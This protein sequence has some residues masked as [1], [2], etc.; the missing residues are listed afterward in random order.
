MK[1]RAIAA[2][3]GAGLLLASAPAFAMGQFGARFGFGLGFHNDEAGDP[4]SS[5]AFAAGLAYTLDLAVLDLE[6]DALYWGNS[7]TKPDADS[8]Y[9]AVPVI[10]K[11][12]IPVVPFLTL[13]AG[14][15]PRFLLSA[16]QGGN[17]VADKFATMVLYLPIL[18]GVTIPLGIVDLG[19][20]ARYE[21]QLTAADKDGESDARV[22][23]LVFMGGVD[24]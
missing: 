10:A 20:E 17:D 6:I 19:V 8:A 3:L 15:N 22:H 11:F 9:L 16:E 2:I 4:D 7:T 24:F 12:G 1:R 14:L 13:G 23:Q 21:L 5:T 18:V